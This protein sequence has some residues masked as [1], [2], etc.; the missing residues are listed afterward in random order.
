MHA[1]GESACA[2][3]AAV[4]TMFDEIHDLRYRV[5]IHF[6]AHKQLQ[7]FLA[8]DFPRGGGIGAK[9]VA[10]HHPAVLKL[11]KVGDFQI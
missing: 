2:C 4:I 8:R 7:M 3:D 5:L 9:S 10:V 6:T 1:G 11:S